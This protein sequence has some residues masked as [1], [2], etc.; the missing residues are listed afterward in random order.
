MIES[1]EFVAQR[2]QCCFSFK[3]SINTDA[4]L[5]SVDF[6]VNAIHN[7]YQHQIIIH[8]YLS[9][10]NQREKRKNTNTTQLFMNNSLIHIVNGIKNYV[11]LAVG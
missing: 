2:N 7:N 10:K 5:L 3:L 8:Y 1:M 6:S 9:T 4:F 11:D